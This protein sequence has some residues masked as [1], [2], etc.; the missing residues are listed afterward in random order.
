MQKQTI[1][2]SIYAGTLPLLTIVIYGA[3]ILHI[4]VARFYFV[5]HH[6]PSMD[7]V[8]ANDKPVRKRAKKA[9]ISSE[10]R[11]QNKDAAAAAAHALNTDI[12]TAIENLDEVIDEIALK[13]G[14]SVEVIQELLHLGSH[15]LKSRRAVGINNAYAHCEARSETTCMFS[16]LLSCS[17]LTV[18][19]CRGR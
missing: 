18:V 4:K 5:P 11:T 16:A 10:L 3:G 6:L 2:P 12:V 19:V 9:K 7:T 15:V 14:K 17:L 1:A 13:H 8:T